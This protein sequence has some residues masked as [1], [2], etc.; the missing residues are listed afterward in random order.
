MRNRFISLMAVGG[1]LLMSCG[2]DDSSSDD[3]A[4]P[5]VTEEARPD[6]TEPETTEPETT[7]P[8]VTEPETNDAPLPAE[9]GV[10]I[11]VLEAEDPGGFG[12]FEAF[13]PEVDD[14]VICNAGEA[15][16]IRIFD[17]DTAEPP[18]WA[19]DPQNLLVDWQ[20]TCADGSGEFV[21]Q[22][23]QPAHTEAETEQNIA[24]GGTGTIIDEGSTWET[25]SGTDS[26]VSLSGDGAL[27]FE[28]LDPSGRPARATWTGTLS[29]D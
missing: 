19:T 17:A 28:I 4:A 7:E 26:Y 23:A 5:D 10:T 24:T 3:T 13:G 27:T 6:A 16:I 8:D 29:A 21:L 22:L 18:P 15:M 2:G 20:F 12:G 1:L 11:E 25:L 14:G 9:P